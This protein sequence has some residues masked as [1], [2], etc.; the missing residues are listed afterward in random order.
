MAQMATSNQMLR[1]RLGRCCV[2]LEKAL[3]RSSGS[4]SECALATLFRFMHF[5]HRW[6]MR[7]ILR[8]NAQPPSGV[9][10]PR[11]AH[12]RRPSMTAITGRLL[13]KTG[14]KEDT[15]PVSLLRLADVLQVNLG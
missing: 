9:I 1:R 6:P 10:P 12:G 4:I 2:P 3:K 13:K 14:S 8:H 15:T 11:I 7:L 5:D